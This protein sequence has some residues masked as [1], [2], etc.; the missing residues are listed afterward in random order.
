MTEE[1]F[2]FVNSLPGLPSFKGLPLLPTWLLNA[3]SLHVL[4]MAD[5]EAISGLCAMLFSGSSLIFHAVPLFWG[6]LGTQCS[7][8]VRCSRSCLVLLPAFLMLTA[9]ACG[10]PVTSRYEFSAECD[11][12][13]PNAGLFW[14][15][16]SL[17]TSIP[18]YQ[19]MKNILFP[20][21]LVP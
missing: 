19:G 20:S 3:K 4:V 11:F 15:L 2:K 5:R 6:S 8:P 10:P 17:S 16:G 21:I 9:G 1:K 18:S 13:T 14:T 7:H 12:L